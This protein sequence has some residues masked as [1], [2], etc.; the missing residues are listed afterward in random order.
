VYDGDWSWA[1]WFEGS[2]WR[3]IAAADPFGPVMEVAGI[4][5]VPSRGLRFLPRVNFMML[6]SRP[7][8]ATFITT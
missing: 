5:T 4:E 1:C 3:R 7:L 2:S 8:N 6:P